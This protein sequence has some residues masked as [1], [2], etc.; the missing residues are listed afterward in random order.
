MGRY[1]NYREPRRHGVDD[2]RRKVIVRLGTTD[3]QRQIVVC[4]EP[5]ADFP[6]S[7]GL[8]SLELEIGKPAPG[9]SPSPPYCQYL[10]RRLST[11][12]ILTR[13]LTPPPFS[14]VR[15]VLLKRRKLWKE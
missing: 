13:P 3:C 12:S 15:S 5:V 1:K 14:T 9:R 6:V 8:V 7:K 4:C 10:L 11:G 2:W